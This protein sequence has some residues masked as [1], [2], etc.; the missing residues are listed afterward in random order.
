VKKQTGETDFDVDRARADTRHCE[1]I[2]HFNNT[3]AGQM[4]RTVADVL[5]AAALV[6]PTDYR[7]RPDA[8][9]FENWEQYFAGKAALGVAVDY[10]MSYGMQT[11]RLRI[12]HLAGILR[13]KLSQMEGVKVT[14]EGRGQCG[15]ATF[16]AEPLSPPEIQ[17]RLRLYRINVST[18]GDRAIWCHFANAGSKRS[19]R[20]AALLQHG[21]G[22]RL[23]YQNPADDP[24]KKGVTP[25]IGGV[26]GTGLRKQAWLS[27]KLRGNIED[28]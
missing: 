1:D 23:F 14:D 22:N 25:Q 26:D 12:Y 13:K 7:M 19:W 15:I 8:R 6:S 18:S 16:T 21:C 11:I 20:L 9:R 4:P 17:R 2:V 24:E 10:A 28:G 3:V 27:K 5:L